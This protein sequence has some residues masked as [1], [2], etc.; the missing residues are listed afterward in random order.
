MCTQVATLTVCTNLDSALL[1]PDSRWELPK[2]CAICSAL[3]DVSQN[4][5]GG[6]LT[7]LVG[8]TR[9]YQHVGALPL[10]AEPASLVA[11]S[12]NCTIP[13][14]RLGS[15]SRA[16]LASVGLLHSYTCTA[17]AL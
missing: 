15:S 16:Q 10:P 3:S 13:G 4:E 1:S 5:S 9:C 7:L 14:A 8:I 17:A 11:F 12:E 6:A 2:T